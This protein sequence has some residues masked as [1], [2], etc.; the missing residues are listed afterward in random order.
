LYCEE[1]TSQSSL[2]ETL[3]IGGTLYYSM[4]KLQYIQELDFDCYPNEYGGSYYML[5]S[6]YD[7]YFSV[8]ENT[9]KKS[10]P[11]R[12]KFDRNALFR[13][14]M[15]KTLMMPNSY[16]SLIAKLRHDKDLARIIGL[17]PDRIPSASILKKFLHDLDIETL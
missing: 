7:F 3:I 2:I 12:P 14:L 15:L 4:Q 11:R 17:D 10:G 8:F 9:N 5:F 16:R 13:C 6:S 1:S